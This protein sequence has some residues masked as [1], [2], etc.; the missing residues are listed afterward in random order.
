MPSRNTTLNSLVSLVVGM[1]IILMS[2]T[3]WGKGMGQTRQQRLEYISVKLPKRFGRTTF[4][5]TIP[6][7]PHYQR[8]SMPIRTGERYTRN[9]TQR[10]EQLKIYTRR[11]YVKNYSGFIYRPR[12][13]TTCRKCNRNVFRIPIV[14]F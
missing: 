7:Q 3:R 6:Y 11:N 9:V 14:M 12:W 1:L 4:F 8:P 10:L 2:N 13:Y 5:N